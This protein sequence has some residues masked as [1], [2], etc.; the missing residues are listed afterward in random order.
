MKWRQ[1]LPPLF[2]PALFAMMTQ[3]RFMKIAVGDKID[4]RE[5]VASF[6]VF[7]NPMKLVAFSYDA[8][9]HHVVHQIR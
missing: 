5:P 6:Q 1:Y 2:R 7:S 3:Y 8:V 4:W 9:F